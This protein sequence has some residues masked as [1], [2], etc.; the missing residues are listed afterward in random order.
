MRWKN[1]RTTGLSVKYRKNTNIDSNIVV[2]FSVESEFALRITLHV[3][4]K[5]LKNGT[6]GH[7]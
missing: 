7:F 2:I 1:C 4:V 5:Y 3:K 6:F